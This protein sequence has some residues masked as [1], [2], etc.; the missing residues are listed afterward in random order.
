MQGALVAG[1][2]GDLKIENSKTQTFHSDAEENYGTGAA[3]SSV[4][5]SILGGV[6]GGM[7][8]GGGPDGSTVQP[9]L[10]PIFMPS[11]K[12]GK[13]KGVGHSHSTTSGPGVAAPTLSAFN[14]TKKNFPQLNKLKKTTQQ[15]H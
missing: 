4:V 12:G 11:K 10:P 7:S 3:H 6:S 13:K 15:H 2:A 14:S 5:P 8:V 9:A 1:G